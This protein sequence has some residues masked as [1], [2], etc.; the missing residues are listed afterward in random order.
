[1]FEQTLPDAWDPLLVRLE[2]DLN[3]RDITVED[4]E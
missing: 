2:K 3:D 1:M 4:E